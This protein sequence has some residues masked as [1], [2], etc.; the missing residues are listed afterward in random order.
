MRVVEKP[1]ENAKTSIAKGLRNM[2]A[3][4]VPSWEEGA[5][6]MATGETKGTRKEKNKKEKQGKK[7]ETKFIAHFHPH[8]RLF[9]LQQKS[10]NAIRVDSLFASGV[11][12]IEKVWGGEDE[13][14]AHWEF[15]SRK[16]E[17]EKEKEKENDSETEKRREQEKE[18]EEG[19]GVLHILGIGG[20]MQ[21]SYDDK[22]KSPHTT[23]TMLVVCVMEMLF[24]HHEAFLTSLVIHEGDPQRQEKEKKEE[25]EREKK[26]KKKERRRAKKEEVNKKLKE[27]KRI[28]RMAY[29]FLF[30]QY[31]V[32][33]NGKTFNKRS[34]EGRKK[35]MEEAFNCCMLLLRQFDYLDR[36]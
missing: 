2:I 9:R 26:E 13:Y 17:Q 28:L 11:V 4:F 24:L 32:T 1:Y 12:K 30:A 23:A 3:E 5:I 7:E 21:P 33:F 16:R 6:A 31:K 20:K 14:V 15:P 10:L 36:L 27:W 29:A 25:R 18:A 34:T 35:M 22:S 8:T 19:E